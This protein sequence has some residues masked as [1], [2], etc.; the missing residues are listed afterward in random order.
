[1][2]ITGAS[3]GIGAA[4]ARACVNQG[5][6]VALIGRRID[7]LKELTKEF[8]PAPGKALP[9]VCDVTNRR[10]IDDAVKLTI[11]AFGGIDVSI[12]NAGFGVSGVFQSLDTDDYR[13]QFNTNVFGVIDTAYA[14]YPHLEKSG[15]RFAVVSSVLGKFGRPSMSAYASSKFALCG[16]CESAAPEF[17]AKGVSLT[18]INPG[19]IESDFRMTD[20]RQNFQPQRKDSAPSFLVMPADVAAQHILKAIYKRKREAVITRHGKL[21]VFLSRHFP[22]TFHA[23]LDRVSRKQ[24]AEY[25]ERANSAR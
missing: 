16:W 7:R 18:C 4:L 25:V 5:A 9:I 11:E 15:G 3:A 14:T 2:F 20:N 8:D 22:R 1:M 12:A 6:N 21:G 10:S 19:L 24:V 23:I 13:R 17:A